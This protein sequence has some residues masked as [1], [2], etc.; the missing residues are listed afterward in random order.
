M[1]ER[2]PVRNLIAGGAALALTVAGFSVY[3][4]NECGVA[5]ATE[6]IGGAIGC[7][8]NGVFDTMNSSAS[9][10]QI[11]LKSQDITDKSLN[12]TFGE[13]SMRM[14]GTATLI[15][16]QPWYDNIPF[17]NDTVRKYNAGNKNTTEVVALVCTRLGD[18]YEKELVVNAADDPDGK[19]QSTI[20]V[21]VDVSD[22]GLS[23][24]SVNINAGLLDY[25]AP[26][27]AQTQQNANLW[28]EDTRFI[29][30]GGFGDKEWGAYVF[31]MQDLITKAAMAQA[32][33]EADF[34]LEAIKTR[35]KTY[36]IGA[37]S[38]NEVQAAQV[39]KADAEGKVTVTLGSPAD[40][41]AYYQGEYA[42]ARESYINQTAFADDL[43]IQDIEISDINV[44]SCD[45]SAVIQN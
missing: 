12:M 26:H 14:G 38:T 24:N 22:D 35:I 33:P 2:H 42:K 18:D 13:I 37:L 40:R 39:A 45:A 3:K 36:V 29:R 31:M 44:R 11:E 1:A 30:D 15:W 20:K 28:D 10:E 43:K 41:I 9:V 7:L 21:D 34:N 23:I 27:V 8:A 16:E 5:A 6:G 4:N 25:C 17:Y 19:K 32:C